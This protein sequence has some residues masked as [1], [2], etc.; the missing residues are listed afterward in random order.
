MHK[1][2]RATPTVYHVTLRPDEGH[3]EVTTDELYDALGELEGGLLINGFFQ[4][5][6]GTAQLGLVEDLPD[7]KWDTVFDFED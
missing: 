2:E 1:I 7:S 4:D 5:E 3:T 6:D